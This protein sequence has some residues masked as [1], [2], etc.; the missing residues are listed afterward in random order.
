VTKICEVI[1]SSSFFS[2]RLISFELSYRVRRFNNYWWSEK[3]LSDDLVEILG[4]Q[5]KRSCNASGSSK[6]GN[7]MWKKHSILDY[8]EII[9]LSWNGILSLQSGS[10]GLEFTGEREN[11]CNDDENVRIYNI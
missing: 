6:E 1:R 4:K 11:A 3:L 2:K 5:C 10:K 9:Y 7:Q 8:N